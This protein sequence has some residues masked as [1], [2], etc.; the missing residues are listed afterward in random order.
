MIDCDRGRG[1][2]LGLVTDEMVAMMMIEPRDE[3]VKR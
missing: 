1:D 2:L 3:Q